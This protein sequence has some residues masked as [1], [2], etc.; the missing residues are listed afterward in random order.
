MKIQKSVIIVNYKS[1]HELKNCLESIEKKEI[2]KNDLEV[3]I[4]NNDPHPFQLEKK[5]SFI[6]TLIEIKKNIGFGSACNQGARQARGKF[7]FFLNPD[8]ILIQEN[9]IQKLVNFLKKNP[10]VGV[11]AP[12][13][14]LSTTNC[15]QPWTSGKKTTLFSILFKNTLGKPW[16]KQVPV[17]VDWVSGAALM[18]FK[19]LFEKVGGFDNCFFMYFEDQDFCLKIKSLGFKVFLLP[20]VTVL[21][22]DGKSWNGYQSKKQAYYQSQLLFFKK[23]CPPWQTF[24]LKTLHQFKKLFFPDD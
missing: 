13:L 22:L 1:N 9:T 16:K 8:A 19:N 12:K 7:L 18:T 10:Q 2:Q 23:N 11:V 4:V 5:F 21:H 6:T 17:S 15:P 14:I 3:I 24:L 20:A